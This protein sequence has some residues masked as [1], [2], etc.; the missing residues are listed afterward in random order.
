M[1]DQKISQLPT[2]TGANMA[3]N[4]KF[5]LV[6]TS[7]DATVAT[8]RAEFFKSVPNVTF[9]DND[10]AIFGAGSD[11]QIYH[12]ASASYVSEQGAGPLN[13]LA[14]QLNIYNATETSQLAQFNTTSSKLFHDDAEKLATT[15]TG[16][17]VTGTVTSDGLTVDGSGYVYINTNGAGANPSGDKGLFLNWNK[18]NSIGESTIGFNNQTG[19]APY[20]QFASWDGTNFLRHMRIDDTGDISFYEDTGTTPKFFWDSSAERLGIGTT[21]PTD[22]LDVRG[23]GAIVQVLDTT[24]VAQ[25]VGGRINLSGYYTGTSENTYAQVV[26]K[27]E[28]GTNANRRGYFAVK[29]R[30]VGA[31][32]IERMRIDSDGNVGIGTTAPLTGRKLHVLDTN[33]DCNVRIETTHTNGDARLELIGDSGGA[34]QIRFGDEAASNVGTLTYKHTENSMSFNINSA[35]RMRIDSSGNVLVG[36]ST[37]NTGNVGGGVTNYGFNYG[38][39]DGGLVARFT[40]LTSDGDIMQ[41]RKDGTTV[42]SIRSEGGDIVFGNDTRGLKFRDSDVIPRDMDN[43][44]ADGVVSLGSS[45]SRF[46]DAYL[47]GGVYLGGAVAA[48]KLDDYETGTWTPSFV[49]AQAPDGTVSSL[50]GQ[51]VKVGKLVTLYMQVTGSSLNLTDYVRVQGLPFGA[52]TSNASGTYILGGITNRVHGWTTLASGTDQWYFSTSGTASATSFRASITY[53][54]T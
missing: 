19:L 11:L 15:S 34:S 24:T 47:S 22:E 17:D 35:E 40:R 37:F 33:S 28:N 9:G 53:K 54:I 41:F 21:A 20:L 46:K 44:T 6:D 49:G 13:L 23:A 5:V 14:S 50:A 38:T 4:D 18:S 26:G 29:T 16:I 51:Y 36:Q 27:K 10:K 7:G 25:D 32:L 52:S 12:D 39:V 48:N 30:S 8:T 2:I 43:T 1:A 31:G 3:D 42:G 45:T